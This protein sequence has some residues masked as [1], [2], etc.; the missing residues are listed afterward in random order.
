MYHHRLPQL[1]VYQILTQ[2]TKLLTTTSCTQGSTAAADTSIITELLNTGFTALVVSKWTQSITAPWCLFVNHLKLSA[3]AA[4]LVAP[5]FAP[6][7]PS[8]QRSDAA[9]ARY[10]LAGK[11]SKISPPFLKGPSRRCGRGGN[12][13]GATGARWPTPPPTTPITHPTLLGLDDPA[14]EIY[15][16]SRERYT[17]S[18][19]PE[20]A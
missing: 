15:C 12:S 19:S 16:F 9:S 18:L 17:A 6:P 14:N 8:Q 20:A 4:G 10:F 7:P 13:G 5:L 2:F 1:D 3:L 11:L